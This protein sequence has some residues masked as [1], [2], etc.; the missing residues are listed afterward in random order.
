MP[1]FNVHLT[2]D[3]S[4]LTSLE[5]DIPELWHAAHKDDSDNRIDADAVLDAASYGIPL[6]FISAAF[7]GIRKAFRN[8]GKTKEDLSLEKEAAQ[9]NRTCVALRQ[10]LLEYLV[11]AQA[12]TIDG[13]SLD[14]LI[15]T[16]DEMDGYC[17]AGK[18]SVPGRRELDGIRRSIADFT[19]A[20]GGAGDAQVESATASDAFRTIRELLV[21]QRAC[22]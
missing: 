8:R 18:L 14:E 10:M 15:D 12:G 3:P 2:I 7:Q 4:I 19:A 9:I 5:T 17:R 1:H 16:L 20:I 22:V 11:A 6:G 13:E 21:R